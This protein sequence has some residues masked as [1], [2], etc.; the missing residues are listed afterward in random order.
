MAEGVE[1]TD[2]GSGWEDVVDQPDE[3]TPFINIPASESTVIH[4]QED[5]LGHYTGSSLQAQRRK[6]LE[7]KVN[8]FLK[9][10]ADRDG[11]LPGPLIYDQFVLGEDGR[12]LY[13]KEGHK[14]VTWKNDS[15]RYLALKEF[16]RA[17]WIRMHLFP[18]YKTTPVAPKR[19]RKTQAAWA[20]VMNQLP[21]A[22]QTIQLVDLPQRVSEIGTA[23]KTLVSDVATSTRDEDDL[24]LRELLGLD[25]T[26]QRTRGALVDHIAKLSQLDTDIAQAEKELGAKR[27]PATQ[28]RRGAYRSGSIGSEMSGH[29][30]WRRPQ[31]TVT[32]FAR[33]SPASGKHSSGY[34]TTTRR[35]QSAFARYSVNRGLPSRRS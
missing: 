21:A 10:V 19:N 29:P 7:S 25:E 4:N 1:L 11:L 27:R 28:K 2:L 5:A 34:S 30:A 13:L 14:R 16:G 22:T 9:V 12:T 23:V 24:P 26:L 20:N 33:S 18:D 3:T 8:A 6:L 17:D 15:T 32:L 31:R 35:S